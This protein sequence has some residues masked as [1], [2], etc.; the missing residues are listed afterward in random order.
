MKFRQIIL[1]FSTLPLINYSFAT[2]SIEFSGDGLKSITIQ[3]PALYPE[4]IDYN[5]VTDKFIVGSFR[6]GGVYEVNLDGSYRQLI[7]DKRLNSVLAVR[8]DVVRNKLFVVNSDIGS[9][10]NQYSKGPKKLA[11]LG[12]YELSSGKNISSSVFSANMILKEQFPTESAWAI[13]HLYGNP[14]ITAKC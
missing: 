1:L 2:E 10:I 12:I 7:E 9:S 4:G 11:S 13:M 5:P 14:F 3:K 6:D 8:V